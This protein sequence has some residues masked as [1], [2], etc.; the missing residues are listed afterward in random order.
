MVGVIEEIPMIYT[1]TDYIWSSKL[2]IEI[3]VKKISNQNIILENMMIGNETIENYEEK[4]GK[5]SME[6]IRIKKIEEEIKN[7]YYLDIYEDEYVIKHKENLDTDLNE[8][9]NLLSSD[10]KVEYDNKI[11]EMRIDGGF[12]EIKKYILKRS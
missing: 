3:P 10:Y 5:N 6:Y 1:D 7:K 2:N 9:L 12:N 11:R 8:Y 4:Y